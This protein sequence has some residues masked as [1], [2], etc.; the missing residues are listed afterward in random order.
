MGILLSHEHEWPGSARRAVAAVVVVA[1]LIAG[2]GLVLWS[3]NGIVR[4]PRGE[5]ADFLYALTGGL[6][7]LIIGIG[8]A[9]QLS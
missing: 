1:M 8:G 2:V 6:A 4:S 3:L 5:R 7:L 9:T